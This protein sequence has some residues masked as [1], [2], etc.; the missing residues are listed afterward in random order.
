MRQN[1]IRRNKR[2]NKPVLIVAKRAI[3]RINAIRLVKVR[4]IIKKKIITKMNMMTMTMKGTGPIHKMNMKMKTMTKKMKNKKI[5]KKSMNMFPKGISNM[6]NKKMS[7]RN[8]CNNRC[9]WI[10]KNK[11][12]ISNL[13]INKMGS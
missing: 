2:K 7:I 3:L 8:I 13:R 11:F 10:N 6:I 5:K 1:V 9:N 4:K 12:S